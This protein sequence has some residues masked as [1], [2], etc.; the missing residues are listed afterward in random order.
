LKDNRLD[1]L[2]VFRV[3]H[4]TMSLTETANPS[5]SAPKS[6]P[7]SLHALPPP[8][9]AITNRFHK[10]DGRSKA[11]RAIKRRMADLLH[12][13]PLPPDRLAVEQ[14]RRVA[15]LMTMAELFRTGALT[16]AVNIETA[17]KLESEC[18]RQQRALMAMR[19]SA[20]TLTAHD[21]AA[22]RRRE[23]K[24]ARRRLKR[25]EKVAAAKAAQSV[26]QMDQK[27]V[28]MDQ[29]APDVSPR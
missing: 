7:F 29:G 28:Q 8:Y 6:Q 21:I 10:L 16:G 3:T 23:A 18:R 11:F 5:P 15:E 2:A 14:A 4:L 17:V 13:F 24:N 22:A 27:P 12:D 20:P 9:R 1:I 19:K 25:R 26:V